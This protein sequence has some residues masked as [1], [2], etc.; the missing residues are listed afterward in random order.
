MSCRGTS[1]QNVSNIRV[2]WKKNAFC[3]DFTLALYKNKTK[4]KERKKINY[5]CDRN[6]NRQTKKIY[7]ANYC[8][9]AQYE[10]ITISIIKLSKI[11]RNYEIQKIQTEIKENMF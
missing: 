6:E 10:K 8:I 7:L 5:N 11:C 9:A 1:V 4:N 3:L 2:L